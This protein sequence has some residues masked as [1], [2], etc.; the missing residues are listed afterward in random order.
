MSFP[1]H[2][3]SSAHA[4]AR[5]LLEAARG[6]YGFV[7]NLFGV[8]AHSPA[9]LRAYLSLSDALADS[10]LTPSERE[11]VA[12]AVS[13]ENGCA[14]CVAA[15]ST[16][17]DMVKA[18]AQAVQAARSGE[19][20]TDDRLEALRQ[21]ATVVVETRGRLPSGDV[22]R[23]LAAGFDR[24]QILDVLTIV[25]MK[26]LSNYANHLADTPLDTPF[27]ARRWASP[28]PALAAGPVG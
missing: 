26:T 17:A 4:L 13:V 7:P 6:K 24:G 2:D 18:P 23:F 25:A 27:A 14:Y 10:Q 15:H 22:S 5:P 19:A 9:A 8:L 12:I 3:V 21:F 1:V 16:V 11:I 28:A 20:A